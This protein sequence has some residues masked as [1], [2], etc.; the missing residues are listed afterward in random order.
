V[1]SPSPGTAGDGPSSPYRRRRVRRPASCRRSAAPVLRAATRPGCSGSDL[2]SARP[3]S[4]TWNGAT[5][6]VVPVP[7]PG[8]RGTAWACTA[9]AMTPHVPEWTPVNSANGAASPGVGRRLRR[10]AGGSR[11]A[12]RAD[13][14]WSC[15]STR[16]C[17]KTRTSTMGWRMPWR[18]RRGRWPPP[19]RPACRRAPR[20]PELASLVSAPCSH[21]LFA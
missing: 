19:T 9:R 11:L 6:T 8:R 21:L 14:F 10:I 12:T 16:S 3:S 13:R 1:R 2:R 15:A 7:G 17:R 20:R 4:L 5:W 18:S